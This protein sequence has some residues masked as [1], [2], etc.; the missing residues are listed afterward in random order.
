MDG[1]LTSPGNPRAIACLY[2][3]KGV[4]DNP[5]GRITAMS[6]AS[7]LRETS[8]CIAA[9]FAAAL[10]TIAQAAAESPAGSGV[11]YSN[12][13]PKG[14]RYDKATG[15]AELGRDVSGG[16]E[17]ICFSF[18]PSGDYMATSLKLPL[19]KAH[20]DKSARFQ[21]VVADDKNGL[22][23]ARLFSTKLLIH[24]SHMDTI[25]IPNSVKLH[26]DAEHTYW[27]LVLASPHTYG[28]WFWNPRHVQ[29]PALFSYDGGR[30]WQSG[31]TFG[32][33]SGAL[34]VYGTRVK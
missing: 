4:A 14:D 23:G 15:W 21:I 34:A 33:P 3:T 28:G 2:A 31:D 18:K 10:G 5:V 6:P 7:R 25:A 1:P 27:M 11:V 9:C 19:G 17:A 8:H 16:P 22:P 30:T 20:S 12:L 26:L 24:H 32:N 13:G 29:S